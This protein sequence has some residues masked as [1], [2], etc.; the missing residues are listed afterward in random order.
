MKEKSMKAVNCG[1]CNKK[2]G[3][4]KEDWEW[5]YLR[6]LPIC[7]IHWVEKEFTDRVKQMGII[8]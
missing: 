5:D 4:P 2:L 1:W 7:N 8:H 3:F 6:S